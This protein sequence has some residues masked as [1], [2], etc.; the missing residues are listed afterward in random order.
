M[1][2]SLPLLFILLLAG[3]FLQCRA[4]AETPVV[5]E[6]DPQRPRTIV[7]TDGEI[8]DVDSFIRMLLY[9]NEFEIE[10]LVYSSSMWH[11]K[12]DGKGTPFTSEM[13]MTRNLSLIHI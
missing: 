12:G 6:A 11:Y 4:E 9:A 5:P 1:T 13:E 2:R 7:T 3:T 8:D 10:G